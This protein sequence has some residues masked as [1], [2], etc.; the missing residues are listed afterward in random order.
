MGQWRI[1]HVAQVELRRVFALPVLS[2]SRLLSLGVG[3]ACGVAATIIGLLDLMDPDNWGCYL[4]RRRGHQAQ[5][6]CGPSTAT[7][8]ASAS[9]SLSASRVEALVDPSR[10]IL[11]L[12]VTAKNNGGTDE[13]VEYIGLDFYDPTAGFTGNGG[14]RASQSTY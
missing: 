10:A 11:D 8:E 1:R 6:S 2:G 12:V 7:A 5:A 14:Y 13:M 4:R 3:A 9:I